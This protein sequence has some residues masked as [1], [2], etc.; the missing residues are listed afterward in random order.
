MTA[1][2]VPLDAEE[3]AA[4]LGVPVPALWPKKVSGCHPDSRRI[5][6]GMVFV[7][8]QGHVADGNRYVEDAI[9]RG[10]VAVITD[11]PIHASVPVVQVEDPRRVLALLAQA[12]TGAADR[13]LR[14]TGITG[15]NGKTSVAGFVHQLL[16]H[17]GISAGLL[18]TVAY[19]F[20]ERWIPA[21]RTTPGPP[22]LQEYLRDMVNAGCNEC[23][24]EVSSHALNQD[25]VYGLAFETVVFTNLSQDHLDYHPSM[26]AY[27]EV[28]AKL[29]QFPTVKHRIVGEDLWS[30]KLADRWNGDVISC[31]FGPECTVRAEVLS[32]DLRGSHLRVL[33]P[34]GTAEVSVPMP[35]RHNVRNMLQAVAVL[36]ANG[37]NMEA[38][39]S[40]IERLK[41]APGRLQRIPCSR[42]E[43]LVDYAHTPDALANVLATLRPLTKGK[44][45][46]VFGCGGD[47][48]RTK[49]PL[50][51]QAVAGEADVMIFTSDNPRTEDAGQILQ[52]MRSGCPEGVEPIMEVDRAKAIGK[53][54]DVMQ[55]EDVVLIAGKGHET[56]QEVG[57]NQIPFDDR[58]VVERWLRQRELFESG[59]LS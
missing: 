11:Q 18:G 57:A 16:D 30:R 41:A 45:I 2:E 54:I 48:D 36:G 9:R 12:I 17:V 5:R 7:A 58:V 51:V 52:D 50:M 4:I 31:G 1:Q 15:T 10:A 14:L 39:W 28:K 23:V 33:T 8:I 27:F 56:V 26:D 49:R 13:E 38:V 20:G 46:V 21:R 44:L 59:V 19:R 40:G 37:V 24:M 34:W 53:A 55:S 47:R 43:V 22:E 6:P 29:F 32:E 35:G 42:G 3:W 25:R